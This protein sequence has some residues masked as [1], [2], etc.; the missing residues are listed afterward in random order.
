M[1]PD[2]FCQA[3][4]DPAPPGSSLD[5]LV[6]NWNNQLLAAINEIVPKRPLRPHRNQP[7]WF[8]K[9]LQKMKQDLRVSMAAC[10]RQSLKNIL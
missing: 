7:P 10:S 6:K 4:W 2:G 3:L 5:E 8:T 1:D 9:E